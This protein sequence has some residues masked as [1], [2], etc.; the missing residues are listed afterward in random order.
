MIRRLDAGY[1]LDDDPARID[2]EAVFRFLHDE[3]YWAKNRP[4]DR[5]EEQLAAAGRLVGLYGPDGALCG[6]SRTVANV[7]GLAYLADLFVLAPHRGRGLGVELVRETVERGPYA[8]LRWLVKTEDAQE[9]YARFGFEP[10]EERLL[11][12]APRPDLHA[13]RQP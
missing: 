4:R 8:H 6:F 1:E 11:E 9:L 5:V 2:V 12:R 7:Q 13:S 10:P 3:S